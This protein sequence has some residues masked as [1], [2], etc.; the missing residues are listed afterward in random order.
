LRAAATKRFGE[1]ATRHAETLATRGEYEKAAALLNET[2]TEGMDPSSEAAKALKEDLKDPDQYN[3]ALTPRHAESVDKVRQLL[4]LAGGHR[5][6]GDYRAAKAA[7]NQVLAVD[8]T[9]VAA[10]RGLEE[11]ERYIS[12]HLRSERDYTRAKMLNEVDRQWETAVPV[13]AV[14]PGV[15]KV[16]G[17]GEV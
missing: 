6:I 17:G 4:R 15:G 16:G 2:L 7:Y 10:R 9:N 14:L 12:N 5:D 1:A 8:E 13:R 11:V 3:P